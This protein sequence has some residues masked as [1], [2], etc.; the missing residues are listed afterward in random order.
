MLS[1]FVLRIFLIIQTEW[2]IETYVKNINRFLGKGFPYSA[3]ASISVEDDVEG[4]S[5]GLGRKKNKK[6]ESSSEISLFHLASPF[7]LKDKDDQSGTQAIAKCVLQNLTL[8]HLL[9]NITKSPSAE[10][11][12]KIL[13]LLT[14]RC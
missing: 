10:M 13:D 12:E 2:F 11:K 1:C 4:E 3:R 8:S 5:Q 9:M 14:G 7:L 6:N